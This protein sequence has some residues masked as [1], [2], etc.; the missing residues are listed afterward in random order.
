MKNL[1]CC[2]PTKTGF[3]WY[4]QIIFERYETNLKLVKLFI[5]ITVLSAKFYCD[6]A[7][8]LKMPYLLGWPVV[9][10]KDRLGAFIT[11]F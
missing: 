8:D 2:V 11:L 6:V 9:E 3:A 1:G 7:F 4:C 5:F 10:R